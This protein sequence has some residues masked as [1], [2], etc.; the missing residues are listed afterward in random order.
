M[1]RASQVLNADDR[2]RISRAVAAAE[3]TTAAEIIVA[4][5]SASGRYDRAEDIVGLWTGLVA[6]G[7]TRALRPVELAEHGSWAEPSKALEIGLLVVVMLVGFI[8]GAAIAHRI[9]WL[10]HAFASRRQMRRQVWARAEQT[11]CDRRISGP[12]PFAGLLIYVSLFERLAVVVADRAVLEKLEQGA[13]DAICR[14]LTGQL[15]QRDP[16][17]ALCSTIEEVGRRLAAT[18]LRASAAASAGGEN[19]LDNALVIL[20]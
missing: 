16:T 19:P 1:K 10:R 11:F 8:A 15:R 5:A 12:A 17:A 6:L 2:R 3:T 13:L 20:D 4:V 9:G 18:M 14:H 7:V